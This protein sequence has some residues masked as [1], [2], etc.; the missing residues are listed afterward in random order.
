MKPNT[1]LIEALE[2]LLVQ[3]KEGELHSVA[4]S[5]QASQDNGCSFYPGEDFNPWSIMGSLYHLMSMINSQV[6][7]I[8]SAH[9]LKGHF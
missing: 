4:L 2:E 3:A 5:F 8:Q 1:Q 6:E 7:E 9:S